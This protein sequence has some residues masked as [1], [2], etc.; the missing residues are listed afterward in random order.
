MEASC[1]EIE[2]LNN[3]SQDRSTSNDRPGHQPVAPAAAKEWLAAREAELLPVP[4]YHVV[5]TLPGQI[6]DIAYQNK[7]VIYDLLFKAS[8]ET[9]I[10]IAADPKHLGAR[11]GVLSVLHTWG[12]ALTHH[13][14]LHM[15]V[16]GGGISLDGTKWVACR[17][18]FFLPVSPVRLCHVT[19]AG[20]ASTAWASRR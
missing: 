9:L 5:F 7:A 2:G 12:S 20:A 10:T 17:P 13:P 19:Q 16:P 4:Y 6:A 3:L 8:A 1:L 18:G 14:H 11:V 15:I